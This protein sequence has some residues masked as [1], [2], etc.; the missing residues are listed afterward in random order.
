MSL[1]VVGATRA[2]QNAT[3]ETEKTQ[4]RAQPIL[5][6]HEGGAEESEQLGAQAS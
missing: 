4:L 3:Y 6:G 2:A 5:S 1:I